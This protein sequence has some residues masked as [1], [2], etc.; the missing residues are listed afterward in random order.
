M[1]SVE[2]REHDGLVRTPGAWVGDGMK[3]EGVITGI[4]GGIATVRV[5]RTTACD[6]CSASGACRSLG[7]GRDMEVDVA[8]KTGAKEGD[9]VLLE[10]PSSSV[11]KLAFLA[12]MLPALALVAGA[13]VG[14]KLAPRLQ[15]TP[16]LG[17]LALALAFFAAALLVVRSLGRTI[18][19]RKE[20][21]PEMAKILCSPPPPEE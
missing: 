9:R 5:R 4:V 16:E 17:S 12:Y 6:H 7:G 10:M 15:L 1:H 18:G 19:E 13:L 3:E 14:L 20:Y 11:I 21:Q 2:S 8:S